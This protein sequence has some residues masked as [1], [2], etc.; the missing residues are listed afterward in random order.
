MNIRSGLK[1]GALI[2][3]VFVLLGSFS[4]GQMASEA[5]SGAVREKLNSPLPV[6]SYPLKI[7]NGNLED[8][9]ANLLAS[10]INSIR[11]TS[12][13]DNTAKILILG[14]Y[15]FDNPG[16]DTVK[17]QADN[18]LSAR[19]QKEI[20]ELNEKLARFKPT[21]IAIE[22][23]Y[24]S[25]KWTDLYAAFLAGKYELGRNEIEQIGFRLAKQFNHPTVYP[26]DY[27]MSMSGYRPDEIE[28]PKPKPAAAETKKSEPKTEKPLSEE[29]KLL[30]SSTVAEYLRHLNTEEKYLD[31][32]WYMELLLPKKDSVALYDGADLLTNW[33]KRNFRMFANINRITEFP[34]DRILL[35]V[36]AGHLKILKELAAGSPQF[37]LAN[38][39]DFLR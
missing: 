11:Q 13:G 7:Q 24:G 34:N 3:F 6:N 23:Q 2:I 16:L 9:A 37:C 4:F 19:R 10:S 31:D 26:I 20:A 38:T 1:F 32:K 35:V 14:T 39:Q 21:K 27:Q 15:H 17:S 36:G 25:T 33:Y 18:V 8:I 30:R 28:R 12:C 29:D 5:S 22:S